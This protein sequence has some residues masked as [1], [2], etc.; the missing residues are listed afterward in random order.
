MDSKRQQIL[1]SA[2]D[3]ITR[4]GYRRTSMED[5]ARQAGISRP[6]IYQHFR[7][8]EA[9][10]KA[11]IELVSQQGFEIA[12]AAITNIIDKNERLAAY[13]TAY[14][15]F[16]YRLVVSGPHSQELMQVKRDFGSEQP[17]EG[18]GRMSGRLNELLGL[19]PDDETGFVLGSAAEGIKMAAGSEDILRQ[20]IAMLV[21]RFS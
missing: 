14:M 1:Q 2:I 13:L 21:E 18:R 16:Y 11:A 4:Y 9:V 20:R 8:K 6:A 15:L 3:T 17:D 19:E 7:N 10:A 5:I 12:E